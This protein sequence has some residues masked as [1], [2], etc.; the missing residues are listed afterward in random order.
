MHSTY[1]TLAGLCLISLTI[2]TV[3]EVLKKAGRLDTKNKTTFAV[4]F[5]AMCAMLASWPVMCPLD[6]WPIALPE[7]VRW[8]GLGV[9]VAGL[10]LAFGGLVQLR[11]V[12][13]IDHLVTTGLFAR[14]RHP[15]YAGFIL[16]IAGWVLR[17][18]AGVSLALGLLCIGNVLY[19]RHLEERAMEAQYGETYRTYRR[20]TW[21]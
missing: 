18:G 9:A 21:F 10:A 20:R 4:V 15:M 3:Y 13:N 6:P 1:L 17:H 19:W 5:V 2:R 8:I 7:G 12:E 14:L 16:W 11:G